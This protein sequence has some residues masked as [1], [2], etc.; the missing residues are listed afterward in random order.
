MLHSQTRPVTPESSWLL[1]KLPRPT[2]HPIIFFSLPCTH[3]YCSM[4]T[5]W[6]RRARRGGGGHVP[7]PRRRPPRGLALR[8][9]T[10]EEATYMGGLA[11]EE[12]VG[13]AKGLATPS[14][15][16]PGGR[17]HPR[18]GGMVWE[19]W[20]GHSPFPGV[21]G[22]PPR[23]AGRQADSRPRHGGEPFGNHGHAHRGQ[24]QARPGCHLPHHW[25]R[26][27]PH[28]DGHDGHQ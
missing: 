24:A 26:S 18:K 7:R 20:L 25:P 5:K 23:V 21:A 1:G 22:G 17:A 19:K 28:E 6:A 14:K 9:G 12:V 4:R 11:V 16:D 8:A 3:K 13:W 10:L 15:V 27:S 2:R